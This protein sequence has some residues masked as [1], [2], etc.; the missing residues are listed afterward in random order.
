MKATNLTTITCS[1]F[2]IFLFAC[3]GEK[4]EAETNQEA[5]LP[6]VGNPAID[7][8][9]QKIAQNP[10]DASLY[11]A[12][13]ELF[14]Q[15]DGFDEAIT[16]LTKA[17]TLDSLN[18]DYHHLLADI[19]LDYF[20][21]RLALKT[22]E[23]AVALY[24]ERIPT[25]LKLSEFQHIL[26]QYDASMQTIDKIMKIDPQ[27]AEGYFMFGRNFR[28]MGD[29]VRAI[30]SFQSAVENDPGLVEAWIY[31]GQ[32]YEGIGDPLAARYY[33]NALEVAPDNILGLH[34]KADYLRNQNDLNGAIELYKK[35]TV[36]DY[37]YEPAYYNAGLLY[38]E[39][40]SIDQAYE[41]FDLTIK[42]SPIHIR[43]YFYRG[44]CS[45]LKGDIE[46]ARTD[47]EQALKMK[48]DYDRAIEG[49]NRLQQ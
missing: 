44:Y 11:A 31:L 6:P 18:V 40:D 17:L 3:A 20:K 19:Y 4:T 37:H 24:P 43:G 36:L 22:M 15:N 7:G 35:I 13:G 10:N 21:S 46:A 25:L 39:M 23:R 2:L 49:M 38:L 32:L 28:E 47:Y 33:D 9:S 12:R 8:V 42:T 29:T 26:T 41:Q 48:P 45:E 14:Y 1:L 5:V 16:D 27:N 30:N 34:A